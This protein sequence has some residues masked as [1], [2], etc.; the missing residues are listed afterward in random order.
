V[1]DLTLGNTI[2]LK[3]TTRA[4]ATGIPGTLAG[5]PVISVYEEN[6]LVQITGG[7]SLTVDYDSVTGL[8][9]ITIVATTGN[10]YEAGKSYDA[11]ITT[12]TVGGVSVVGEVVG[13]FT[14][15]AAA[16]FTRLATYRLGE[17]MSAALAS[18][19]FAAS[20]L[21]DLTQDNPDAVGTQQFTVAALMRLADEVLTGATHNITNSWGRRV[22]N[23]EAA[24]VLRAGTAQAGSA[25]TITLDTGA[26]ATDDF[27]NHAKAVIKSGTGAEQE[28]IIVAYAG[29]TKVATVAPPWVVSPD[30][31]SVF[32]V[33]PGISHAETNS[34]TVAVGI[35]QT[36][37]ALTITL[38]S[39][40]SSTDEYY[41]NDTVQIDE[42]TGEGQERIITAYNGTTKVATVNTAWLVNPDTT[43]AYVVEGAL[44]VAGNRVTANMDQINGNATS[45]SNLQ[46]STIAL[47]P[48]AAITGTLSTTQMTTD[49]T[50]ATDDH[51]IGRIII[52]ISGVLKNQATDITGYVGATKMLTFTATTEAPADTD[53]FVIV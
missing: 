8:N 37:A 46:K 2:Y 40:A 5:T 24:F 22:R 19:P 33:E 18:Q 10:G 7:V 31:T 53:T 35:A 44:V 20:L 47:E 9:Q 41:T 51:Y 52:W 3:F 14:V 12:G 48:G 1:R 43:S 16:A 6:N 15:E 39:T 25:N 34:K 36:G 21:G 4:F 26:N 45:A 27:Y 42:G 50:E 13:S 38:A 30:A 11:V 28:R 23:I 32:A 29:A 17:L 49:L